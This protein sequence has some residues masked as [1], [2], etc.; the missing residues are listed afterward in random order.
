MSEET[1]HHDEEH[2]SV[3]GEQPRDSHQND[4]QASHPTPTSQA[5]FRILSVEILCLVGSIFALGSLI[6]LHS[7]FV[8]GEEPACLP[9][10]L[11]RKEN[12]DIIT[13]QIVS[14]EEN[15][16]TRNTSNGGHISLTQPVATNY[17][18]SEPERF[19]QTGKGSTTRF[20]FRWKSFFSSRLHNVLR[21]AVNV[22]R[23]IHGRF[24]KS[25]VKKKECDSM[26]DQPRGDD[27]KF[28]GSINRTEEQ[29]EPNFSYF[30][31]SKLQVSVQV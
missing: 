7:S 4:S 31:V 25:G 20:D 27:V 22:I 15:H 16:E 30:L 11:I 3:M 5:R 1:A 8:G 17:S 18:D 12:P 9:V 19:V 6:L 13:I 29:P 26:P 24:H 14:F 10:D 21:R 28:P 23:R 2:S